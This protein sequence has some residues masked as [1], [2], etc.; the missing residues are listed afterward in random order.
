MRRRIALRLFLL[1]GVGLA[2]AAQWVLADLPSFSF[3]PPG[4]VEQLTPVWPHPG[5]ALVAILLFVAAAAIFGISAR[6]LSK[7]SKPLLPLSSDG[8]V[9]RARRFALL[10]A[11]VGLL[12]YGWIL[13]RLWSNPNGPSYGPWFALALLLVLAGA[14]A[15]EGRRVPRGDVSAHPPWCAWEIVL[16]A[17]M[18]GLFLWLNLFDVRDG[19]YS[20]IGDEFDFHSRSLREAQGHRVGNL[21]SQRG[22]YAIIPIFS[23]W[24]RGMLMRVVG[25]D[26]VG[27]KAATILPVAAA[28]ALAYLL[29]RTLYGRRVAILTLGMLTTAHYLL[30]YGHTGYPNLEPLFP[31]LGALLFFVWGRNRDSATL[32]FVS[33]LFAGL[34]WYTYYSSRTAIVLL[35][36]GVL[37]TLPRSRWVRVAVPV[38]CGFLLLFLPLIV[39][40]RGST[41]TDMLDQTW[42]SSVR[43]RDAG[44]IALSLINAGRSLLA[45][46]Y[47]THQGPFLHGS[48][49]EPVTAALFP[50]GAG[51]LLATMQEARSR[52]TLAWFAIGLCATGVLSRYDYVPVSRLHYVLPAVVLMAAVALDRTLDGLIPPHSRRR[53]EWLA[54]GGVL[55]AL[56]AVAAS[57]LHRW[58]VV[59]PS[60]VPSTA[61]SLAVQ[62]LEKSECQ[63]AARPPLIVDEG[64]VGAMG[65][66]VSARGT[67][68]R[69]EFAHFAEAPDWIET[70]PSRC[71]IFYSPTDGRALSLIRALEARWPESRGVDL[72]DLPRSKYVRVYFPSAPSSP[73]GPAPVEGA[74]APP[75]TARGAPPD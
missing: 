12:L 62:V 23:S 5:P 6:G 27:W 65:P 10:L 9:P 59:A 7:A 66:A 4:W 14:I 42:S 39:V 17:A 53:R 54:A 43:E 34:G 36:C 61:D 15:R 38:A 35:A 28:L 18:I 47:N 72:Y 56:A 2:A 26:L 13:T 40:N 22:S 32:L 29:A 24:S 64:V 44:W 37:L 21:F 73:R 19:Y 41:L 69:P 30:A 49:A 75:Q 55:I 68:I 46:N 70:A 8:S 25:T 31:A 45:F 20:V 3:L 58:F 52:L 1:V 51:Y 48:L 50:L 67:R 11:G 74:S 57:N 63:R 60:L 16:V 33:G 71:V